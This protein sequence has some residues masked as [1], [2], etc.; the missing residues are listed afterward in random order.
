[1]RPSYRADFP[2]KPGAPPFQSTHSI[3]IICEAAESPTQLNIVSLAP[4]HIVR[5]QRSHLG[6]NLLSGDLSGW[7][8]TIVSL[9]PNRRSLS[10]AARFLIDVG[11]W[12]GD[13]SAGLSEF[14]VRQM[15]AQVPPPR[16]LLST[17]I[18]GA[19]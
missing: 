6:K 4:I 17:P 8:P 10:S 11:K 9:R 16:H 1:M 12:V 3:D 13:I 5:T 15:A 2:H 19:A 7:T 14:S 18:T